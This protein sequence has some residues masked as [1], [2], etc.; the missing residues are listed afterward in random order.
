MKTDIFALPI[1]S[2]AEV[3]ALELVIAPSKALST[4]VPE[5][6]ELTEDV[7][8]LV[9]EMARTMYLHGGV[10]LAGNQ[11]NVAQPIRA[12]VFDPL[13]KKVNGAPLAD[14]HVIFNPVLVDASEE[15]EVEEGCLS[16]PSVFLKKK[17][18][19]RVIV[20]GRDI[21]WEEHEIEAY[22]LTATILQH[23]IDHLDG[24]TM[25]CDLSTLKKAGALRKVKKAVKS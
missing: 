21:N 17:R 7:K 10:G 6:Q 3:K 22:G 5:L 25:I 24:K 18:A 19:G 2:L 11:V 4:P 9:K 20:R 1:P 15:G 12:I 14:P 8:M 13:L 16:L 23:E